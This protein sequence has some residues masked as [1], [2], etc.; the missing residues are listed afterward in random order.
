MEYTICQEE[1]GRELQRLITQIQI[2]M[3]QHMEVHLQEQ[4]KQVQNMQQS[5]Q[6]IVLQIQ[7]HY[8]IQ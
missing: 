2:I 1:L 7:E 4:Q 6:T 5:T 8:Y 3:R